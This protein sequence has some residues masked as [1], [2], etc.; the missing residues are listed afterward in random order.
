MF[1]YKD[2][3]EY[4]DKANVHGGL[5]GVSVPAFTFGAMDD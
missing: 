3:H 5:S 4:Y 1:G 2:V